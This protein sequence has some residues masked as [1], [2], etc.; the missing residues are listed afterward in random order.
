MP[1]SCPSRERFRIHAQ[2]SKRLNFCHTNSRCFFLRERNHCFFFGVNN[3]VSLQAN[4]VLVFRICDLNGQDQWEFHSLRVIDERLQR[5]KLFHLHGLGTST[6]KALPEQPKAT[7]KFIL[8]A[9]ISGF[10]PVGDAFNI[11][12]LQ[13]TFLIQ[14][15]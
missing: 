15:R 4:H 8:T 9:S 5:T 6:V 12:L 14:S 7:S 10:D 13:E 11:K 1:A 2:P 3:H